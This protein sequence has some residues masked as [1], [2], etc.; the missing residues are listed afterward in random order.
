MKEQLKQAAL[1]VLGFVKK[2]LKF[3]LDKIILLLQL[4]SNL[5]AD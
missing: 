4:L 1:S 2:V 3:T 5:L